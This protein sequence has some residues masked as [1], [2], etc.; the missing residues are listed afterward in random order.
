ME[1][2]AGIARRQTRG[3]APYRNAAVPH[4]IVC[5]SASAAA[6]AGP[7]TLASIIFGRW[8]LE[9]RAALASPLWAEQEKRR[10]VLSDT[11]TLPN[12]SCLRDRLHV[13]ARLSRAK[14]S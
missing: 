14:T 3:H 8:E 10:E 7:P 12:K 5:C 2:S 1:I 9:S 11:N 4:A 6:R 13:R